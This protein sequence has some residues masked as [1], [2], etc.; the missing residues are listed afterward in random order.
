MKIVHS[1]K[2]SNHRNLYWKL[3]TSG[4][5]WELQLGTTVVLAQ[6]LESV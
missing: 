1:T 2:N 4:S 6:C 3:F 5:L